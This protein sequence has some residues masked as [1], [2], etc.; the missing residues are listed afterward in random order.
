MSKSDK[1]NALEQFKG[2]NGHFLTESLFWETNKNRDNIAPVFTLKS[3]EHKGLPSLKQLYLQHMDPTEY[4]FAM[5]VFG[6]WQHWEQLKS[7]S[8][9]A[10]YAEEWRKEL[11]VLLR[12]RAAQA[13]L[14]VL[15]SPDAPAATKMQAARYVADSGWEEK[16][17]KGRPTK[18]E[19]AKAARDIAES[20]KHIEDD[21]KRIIN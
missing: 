16:H 20:D 19:V 15:S 8:W 12:S 13:A 11:M 9:F 10:P 5:N 21:F 14:D 7:L 17:T 4:T 1:D 2:N 18:R 3:V 6:S